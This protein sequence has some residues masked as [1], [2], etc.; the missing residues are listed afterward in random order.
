MYCML[1]YFLKTFVVVVPSYC[2]KVARCPWMK[3]FQWKYL[4]SAHLVPYYVSDVS[5]KR[6]LIQAPL[7][8]ILSI[9]MWKAKS[10]PCSF[11]LEHFSIS[12]KQ[13]LRSLIQSIMH[14]RR[15]ER[16][17]SMCSVLWRSRPCLSWEQHVC[18]LP[19]SPNLDPWCPCCLGCQSVLSHCRPKVGLSFMTVIC[20]HTMLFKL[21]RNV[22]H[23]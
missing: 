20:F 15:S 10:D 12:Q 18:W 13:K 2:H 9:K 17:C 19:P 22:I 3:V 23:I 6:V 21:V 5:E 14:C 1:C 11:K 4:S 7:H 8:I 16:L